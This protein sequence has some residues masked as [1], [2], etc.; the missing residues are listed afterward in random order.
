M[1]GSAAKFRAWVPAA[2]AVDPS[3]VAGFAPLVPIDEPLSEGEPTRAPD[4]TRQGSTGMPVRTV[5][6]LSN[7][8]VTAPM[9]NA[10]RVTLSLEWT[11]LTVT[12][13]E[14]L[15]EFLDVTCGAGA[16]GFDIDVDASG[17]LVTVIATSACSVRQA[18]PG[19]A[20]VALGEGVWDVSVAAVVLAG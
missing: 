10:A 12:E 13:M 7:H 18:G 11:G 17:D 1:S 9:D 2:D 3:G 16:R 19:I 20:G 5:R 15:R 4:L 6:S 14:A 8:R